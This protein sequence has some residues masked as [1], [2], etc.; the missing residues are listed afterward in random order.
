[1]LQVY[2]RVYAKPGKN[3]LVTENPHAGANVALS[4]LAFNYA[5]YT[6]VERALGAS[7]SYVSEHW[8]LEVNIVI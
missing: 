8:C 4:N 1:M 3:G 5:L 2:I 7:S 6:V